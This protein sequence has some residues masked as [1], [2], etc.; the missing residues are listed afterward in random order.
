MTSAR[1]EYIG[2]SIT[3]H[4]GAGNDVIWGNSGK[5]TLFGDTGNDRI[6]GASSDDIIAGGSGNDILH[7]G[8]G[9]DIFTFCSDWGKD[10]VQQ[11]EDGMVILWFK[12][13]L[14]VSWDESTMTC[15][16]GENS[17]VVSGVSADH[18]MIKYGAKDKQDAEQYANL[19]AMGGFDEKTSENVFE[20]T[21]NTLA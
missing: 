6:T 16:C 2:N 20:I 8:G 19:T 12:E 18:V 10:T 14:D 4:G 7:G 11:L 17:V 3:I 13:N 9:T 21:K 5:N 15:S 1:F